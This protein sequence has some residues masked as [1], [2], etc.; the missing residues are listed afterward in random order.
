[1]IPFIAFKNQYARESGTNSLYFCFMNHVLQGV[2][3]VPTPF[4]MGLI[5]RCS[6]TAR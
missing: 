2:N 4:T 6:F 1:M 3:S 5:F